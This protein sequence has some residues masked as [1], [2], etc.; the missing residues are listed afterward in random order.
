MVRNPLVWQWTEDY[1]GD[2]STTTKAYHKYGMAL[3]VRAE[4]DIAG[5][6]G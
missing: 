1:N 6:L 3:T 4:K 2:S 5:G